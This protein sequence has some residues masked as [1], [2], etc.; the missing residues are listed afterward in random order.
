ML[1]SLA[2][3]QGFPPPHPQQWV[4]THRGW[5]STPAT[6]RGGQNDGQKPL[7]SLPSATSVAGGKRENGHPWAW[8]EPASTQLIRLSSH[9]SM[10]WVSQYWKTC[11]LYWACLIKH[12]D[13]LTTTARLTGVN[14]VHRLTYTPRINENLPCM[15]WAP[16][17]YKRHCTKEESDI[18][19]FFYQL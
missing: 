14:N 2:I 3:N 11:E 13:H 4:I 19:L 6:P 5:Y 1:W 8:R 16:G 9:V 15:L 18:L 7:K 10:T 17:E 12:T